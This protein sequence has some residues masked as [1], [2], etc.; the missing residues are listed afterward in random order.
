MEVHVS[1][2]Q[3]LPDEVENPFILDLLVQNGDQD[4]MIHFVEASTDVSFNEP[5]DG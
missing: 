1:C 2:V 5:V 4:L 3:E